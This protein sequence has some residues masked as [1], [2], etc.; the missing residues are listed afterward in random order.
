MNYVIICVA[1]IILHSVALIIMSR[2]FG[3]S[4]NNKKKESNSTT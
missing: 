2:L 3:A 4:S 1:G